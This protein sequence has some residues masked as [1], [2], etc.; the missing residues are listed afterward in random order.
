MKLRIIPSERKNLPSA[1]AFRI[2]TQAGDNLK[3]AINL[4]TKILLNAAV[5]LPLRFPAIFPLTAGTQRVTNFSSF[6]NAVTV[7]E[8]A[9]NRLL[10]L[11][12][13]AH[14]TNTKAGRFFVC[15][16]S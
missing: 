16:K 11:I 8:R 6:P 4:A 9:M 7:R 13:T 10:F 12:L 14:A 5:E 3:P 15:C 2:I 1:A